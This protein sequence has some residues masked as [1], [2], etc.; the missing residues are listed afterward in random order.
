[1]HRSLPLLLALLL[2]ATSVAQ[3]RPSDPLGALLQRMRVR[4]SET[5]S[6][7]LTLEME[8]RFFAKIESL[9]CRGELHLDR[10][11]GT[12]RQMTRV[13]WQTELGE[14][15]TECARNERGVFLRERAPYGDEKL[16]HAK[17]DLVRRVA[18]RGGPAALDPAPYA[19]SAMVAELAADHRLELAGEEVLE[20]VR[21]HVLRGPA[22]AAS[23]ES[24]PAGGAGAEDEDAD[25]FA[26]RPDSVEV[27]VGAGDLVV[28]KVLEQKDGATLRR[29][30]VTRVR[31]NEPIA[32]SVFE[33][34]VPPGARWT[35]LMDDPEK[36]R[37]IEELLDP[38]GKR[39][40]GT[41]R[42]R[43]RPGR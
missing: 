8:V 19:G 18:E 13:V 35:D 4:E 1:V 43:P 24:R 26:L 5:E 34:E 3:S 38:E 15:E 21:C 2:A 11:G 28:R 27:W 25:L 14:I 40:P 10:R 32:S 20:G 7:S 39:D 6:L 16:L 22:V 12:S 17:P 41:S 29:M 9:A 23:R 30:S 31:V 36:R 33:L 37:Q 42:S